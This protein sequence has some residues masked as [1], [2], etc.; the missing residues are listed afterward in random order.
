MSR[1]YISNAQKT[2][3]HVVAVGVFFG[4]I[5]VGDK[6]WACFSRCL[7]CCPSAGS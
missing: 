1:P 5:D 3:H 6:A 2:T 7:E 4:V